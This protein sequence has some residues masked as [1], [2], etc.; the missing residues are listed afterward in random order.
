MVSLSGLP[1]SACPDRPVQAGMS[2]SAGNHRGLIEQSLY[3]DVPDKPGNDLSIFSQLS[4][5]EAKIYHLFSGNPLE[6]DEIVDKSQLPVSAASAILTIL[7]LKRLVKELPG[8]VFERTI[9]D[10]NGQ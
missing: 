7:Q 10:N 9:V 3:L 4:E 2:G 1:R 8:K 6:F 5:E